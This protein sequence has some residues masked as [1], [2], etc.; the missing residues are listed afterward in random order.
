MTIAHITYPLAEQVRTAE[1]LRLDDAYDRSIAG[2]ICGLIPVTFNEKSSFAQ[3]DL[4]AILDY[5]ITSESDIHSL[6]F[7]SPAGRVNALIHQDNSVTAAVYDTDYDTDRLLTVPLRVSDDAKSDAM[8]P[9]LM[10]ELTLWLQAAAHCAPAAWEGKDPCN[11][12]MRAP[13][14]DIVPPPYQPANALVETVFA[15]LILTHPSLPPEELEVSIIGRQILPDGSI[16]AP[17]LVMQLHKGY[18]RDPE[19]IIAPAIARI[20]ELAL[21][22][23][24]NTHH[25]ISHEWD[26]L[27]ERGSVCLLPGV[28][29][30]RDGHASTTLSAHEQIAAKDFLQEQAGLA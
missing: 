30:S 1:L 22:N 15:A 20:A 24:P 16:T 19:P 5:T 21:R 2:Q 14:C 9:Q 7:D 4:G 18:H 13:W 8:R 11:A 26:R 3:A 6:E 27:G 29:A 28:V 23:M 12:N 10:H 17:R 25:L